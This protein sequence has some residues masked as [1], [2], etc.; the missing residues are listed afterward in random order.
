MS[1]GPHFRRKR[2]W[3]R[4]ENIEEDLLEKQSAMDRDPPVH[5][6]NTDIGPDR[7]TLFTDARAPYSAEDVY[8]MAQDPMLNIDSLRRWAKW[9]YYANGTV[10]TA[11]DSLKGLHTLDYVVVGRP[12]RDGASRGGYHNVAEKMHNIL[13]ALRYKEVIR[14]AIFHDANE[15]MYVG[16]LETK[17]IPAEKREALTD[18]DVQGFGEFNSAGMN[19][20]VIHLPVQWTKI[21]G[22]RNNCYEVA[23]DLRYFEGMD[24]V[25]RRRKL[26]GMPKQIQDG[27]SKYAQG[28]L[29]PGACWLRLDWRRTIVGKIKSGQSDP[30]GVPFAVAALDD[31]E[32]ARYF[33]N[34]KRGIL[35]T[36][37]NR[38]YYET[39]PEGK[40]KGTSALT[41]EQQEAQ[42]NTVKSA[43]SQ[44]R[45]NTG[46]SFFSLAAGTKMDSLPVDVAL[47]DEENENAIAEDV[48]E[49]IGFSAAALNGSS[50]GN[51]ATATLNVEIISNNVFTWI[52][53]IV[54]ELNKCIGYNLIRDADYRVEFR[55]LPVTFVNRDRQV[56]YFS[57]LYAR[58][59]G[60]L[61]AW[62]AASGMNP[63]D[64]LALMDYELEED[65]ENRYPVHK[66]SFTVT[67]KD[68]P[69]GDVDGS[70]R[71]DISPGTA[72]TATNNGN[73]S[74]SPSD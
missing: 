45:N 71:F 70:H 36:V 61:L 65:F 25:T 17:R 26:Q 11:I 14:D 35:S 66:T 1:G 21:I 18:M 68:A 37:N 5:E 57:D 41:K 23:F 15:G 9:A 58:G 51:Y 16:Y 28:N 49:D 73:A 64:Y 62:V 46:V 4:N 44:R 24:E 12:K 60:S 3:R 42:H 33:I 7:L 39:F 22:R 27:W 34:T 2:F 63:S 74:P 48:N 50:S 10:T 67:G 55:V 30:Y 6:F 31:I 40:E 52:E 29:P 69:D 72:A 20:A 47:L 56:K 53:E 19:A 8:R 54:D 59:K 38:I 43:L 32:Y 13:R